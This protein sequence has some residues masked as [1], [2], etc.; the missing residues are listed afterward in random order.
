MKLT[1]GTPNPK[2]W[3]RAVE[4]EDL[5]LLYDIENDVSLW[6]VGGDPTPYSRY[7][8]HQYIASQPQTIHQTGQQRFV[9]VETATGVSVGFVD[10]VNYSPTD[11]RAEVSIVLLPRWR[12]CGLGS[13]AL[14]AL[15]RYATSYLHIRLLYA[16]VSKEHNIIAQK[17]FR[18]LGYMPTAVLPEWHFNGDSYEDVQ[19]YQKTF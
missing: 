14:C 11:G 2:V 10:L 4:P 19:V 15:E 8:L 1:D 12:H 13:A 18:S 5:G 3:L 7:A 16:L 17:L 9:V 6:C